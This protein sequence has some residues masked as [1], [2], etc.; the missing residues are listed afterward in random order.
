[1]TVDDACSRLHRTLSHAEV[2]R[3]AVQIELRDRVVDEQT[4]AMLDKDLLE[5]VGWTCLGVVNAPLR[6]NTCLAAVSCR[7]RKGQSRLTASEVRPRMW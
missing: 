5:R 6:F 3:L 2:E 4:T 7:H 1:M